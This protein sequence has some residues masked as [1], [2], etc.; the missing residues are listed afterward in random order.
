MNFRLTPRNAAAI[1]Q[2]TELWTVAIPWLPERERFERHQRQLR[3]VPVSRF[4]TYGTEARL[5][6]RCG[7]IGPSVGSGKGFVTVKWNSCSVG[8][9]I[10]SVP[11]LHPTEEMYN[12]PK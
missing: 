4:G 5:K 10:L 1:G 3:A 12:A 8:N 2:Y 11:F 9:S 6:I 7:A